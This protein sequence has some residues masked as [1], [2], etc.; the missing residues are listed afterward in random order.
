M[1]CNGQFAWVKEHLG[2]EWMKRII[3]T[4]DKTLIQGHLLI[5]DKHLITGPIRVYVKD[6][7]VGTGG[8]LY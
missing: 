2:A 4:R 5:D 8:L 3:V 6:C 1:C 7:T